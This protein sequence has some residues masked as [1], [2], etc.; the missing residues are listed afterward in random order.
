MYSSEFPVTL[1]PNS[2]KDKIKFKKYKKGDY[3][4][5]DGD[6][7]IIYIKKGKGMK[8]RCDKDGEKVFPYM[9]SDDEFIGVNAYFTGGSDWEVI[10]YTD[11]VIVFEIP[12]SI[13]KE[14]ILGTPI[15]IE[16][17]LPKCTKLLFQ[18][19]RGFYIYTQGGAVAYYAYILN[20]FCKD[21][22]IFPFDSYTDMTKSVY[23]N[24]STLYKITKQFIDEGIIEK[25]IH[26]IKIIDRKA[27]IKYFDSYRY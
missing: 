27:L 19:L 20:C 11:E 15:F 2:V 25:N 18:G 24:K 26:S 8:I 5:E 1:L 6:D 21:T 13:F 14:Y 4:Y 12:K 7:K 22:N 16:E 10:A 23:V 9:F 17:Y 3:L